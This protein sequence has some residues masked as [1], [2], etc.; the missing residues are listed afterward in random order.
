[1]TASAATALT[2]KE[3]IRMTESERYEVASAAFKNLVKSGDDMGGDLWFYYG[4]NF[5]EWGVLDSAKFMFQKGA[6]AKPSNPLNFVGLGSIAWMENNADL[7]KQNFYK[8]TSLT[9]TQGTALSK[10]K[11]SMVYL[12]IAEAYLQ[13]QTKN[14]SDAFTNINTALKIDGKNP[15]VYILLGDYWVEKN[16][17]DVSEAIK[18]YEKAIELD[19]TSSKA[20][21][22]LGQMWVRVQNYD[23]GL[24]VYSKAILMD[25]TF[26]PTYR[27]RGDLLFLAKRYKGAIADYKKYLSMNDSRTAREKYAKAIFLT[28][29]YKTAIDEIKEVQK[30]DTSNLILYRLIG[31]SYYEIADYPQGLLYMEK[32]LNRQKIKDKPKLIAMDHSY[33]G[34]LLWKTGKDSFGILEISKAMAMDDGYVVDGYG[35]IANINF[36][37]K[38]YAE[39]A[40]FFELKIKTETAGKKDG[41][42]P[43]VD[44]SSLGQAYFYNKEYVK[45]DSAFSKTT[46]DYPVY[47]NA[48][49]GKCNS[50][51][52]DAEKPVG[53]AKPFYELAIQNAGTD[54]ERNKKDII[55]AYSYLGF[56]YLTQKSF[57]CSKAAW[58]K[59]LEL[60]PANEKATKAME[61]KEMK[62]VQG[63]C[64]LLKKG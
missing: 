60:D 29:D 55:E 21:L 41:K 17:T 7:A 10:D 5:L 51:L 64:D 43:V 14:L 59:V 9:T 50:K 44:F 15:E 54:I 26:A 24:K 42:L 40:K 56:F 31:Y 49:R 63:T 19:K 22:R 27:S 34:K 45:A 13:G 53:K 35:D 4:D 18:D 20:F 11:Q 33:Y 1:M 52:D 16:I 30:K 57:D 36:K 38:R 25:S 37:R 48:W 3:A 39:A 6:D 47:G 2:I 62:A 12:K 58:M 61:S 8:A 32:F 28:K 46:G 23:E